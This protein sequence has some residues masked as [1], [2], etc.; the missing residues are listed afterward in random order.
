MAW[1]VACRDNFAVL[2]AYAPVLIEMD[3]QLY[4]VMLNSDTELFRWLSRMQEIAF[5]ALE[6]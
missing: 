6:L 2:R 3:V 5:G 1:E 4:S